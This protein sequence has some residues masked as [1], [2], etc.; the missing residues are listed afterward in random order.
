VRTILFQSLTAALIALPSAGVAAFPVPT[1]NVNVA[2]QPTVNVGNQ[3]TVNVGNQPTVN[4]AS[5]P[6]V[7]IGTL[8]PVTLT[9]TPSVQLAP[10]TVLPVFT[11]VPFQYMATGLV[12]AGNSF[13]TQTFTVP[14]GQRAVIE[15]A[16]VH[17]DGTYNLGLPYAEIQSTVTTNGNS[18]FANYYLQGQKNF[19]TFD[20]SQAVKIYADPQSTVTLEYLI[21]TNAYDVH[22]TFSISGYLVN[23]P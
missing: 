12:P 21:P 15:F 3:P 22:F 2:N 18:V 19:D 7:N 13:G 9:G 17:A 1:V 14:A 5:L 10:G 16:S 11:G 20:L 6:L 8:P 23:V 4:V